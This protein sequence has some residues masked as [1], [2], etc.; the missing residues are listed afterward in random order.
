M[1]NKFG[2]RSIYH[3]LR[4]LGVP[5]RQF[6]VRYWSPKELLSVFTEAI[7]P[8][9]LSIDGF[10]GLGMQASDLE[11]FL[12]AHRALVRASEWLRKYEL[13]AP[14]ADSL[15]VHSRVRKATV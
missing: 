12:P 8:S 4:Q 2:L 13:L 3:Q 10:F 1:P 14:V 5:E 11:S 15:Y 6:D 9:H 7:G